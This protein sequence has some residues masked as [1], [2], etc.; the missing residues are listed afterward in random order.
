MQQHASPH[1]QEQWARN[2]PTAAAHANGV[3]PL[4]ARC[5]CPQCEERA[6]LWYHRTPHGRPAHAAELLPAR[7]GLRPGPPHAAL[8]VPRPRRPAAGLRRRQAWQGRAGLKAAQAGRARE[9]VAQGR[10]G[11]WRQLSGFELSPVCSCVAQPCAPDI[12]LEGAGASL[13]QAK[14][15]DGAHCRIQLARSM[16]VQQG[17]AWKALANMGPRGETLVAQTGTRPEL[18][19]RA[20]HSAIVVRR[21]TSTSAQAVVRGHPP[22]ALLLGLKGP[23]GPAWYLVARCLPWAR[24]DFGARRDF[25]VRRRDAVCIRNGG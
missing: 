2:A 5:P 19:C 7:R 18:A 3:A 21:T 6:G 25:G 16:R 20:L 13:C 11:A 24:M 14:R 4:P 10:C 9:P 22:H 8:L 23:C 17:A 15:D 1:R 12:A